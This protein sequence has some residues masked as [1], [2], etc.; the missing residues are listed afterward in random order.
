MRA[1]E[2]LLD[3]EAVGGLYQPLRGGDPRPRGALRGDVDAGSDVVAGDRFDAAELEALIDAQVAVA[4]AAA[5]EIDQGALEPRP[6][7]CANNK[8]C[9]YPTICRCEAR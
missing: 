4:V 5:R 6:A 9:L 7:T 8:R 1:A 3:V 2:A